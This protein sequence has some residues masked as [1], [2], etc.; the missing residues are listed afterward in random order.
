[1]HELQA[2]NRQTL[3]KDVGRLEREAARVLAARVALVRLQRLNQDELALLVEHRRIHVV[4]GQ[5]AAAMIGIVAQE[6]IAGAPIVLLVVHETVAHRELRN[7]H[8]VRRADGD[9]GEPAVRIK[10]L[11][12]RSFD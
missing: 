4:V 9:A 5:M 11:P 8:Q 3:G 12:L 10:M 1:M 7:E 2:G 6:H